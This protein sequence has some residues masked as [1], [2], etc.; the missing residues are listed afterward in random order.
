MTQAT[1]AAAPPEHLLMQMVTGKWVS[2]A[3][4]VVADLG[5]PDLLRDGARP[6]GELAQ[7]A[8]VAE[9]PLYRLLRAAAACGV[10]KELP[11]RRFENNALSNLMRTDVPG[12]LRAMVRWICEDCAWQAWGG[13]GYSVKSDRPAFDQVLGA[14]LFEYFKQHP[15]A[16]QVFN[17]AMINFTSIT[18][19]AVAKA[20]DFSAFDTIVDVGG[21]HGALL[22]TIAA[23][24]PR[25]RGIVFD[26]PEVVAGAETYLASCGIA[27]RI[28]TR[29]GDFLENVPP[30]AD[31]YIMKHIIHDW[32]DA[33]STRILSHCRNA[34]KAGGRPGKVLIVDQV[35][36][37]RPEGIFSKLAD[38]EMLVM[39]PGGRER[40]DAEFAELLRS[41][42]LTM[43]RIVPTESIVSIVEAVSQ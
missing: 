41:A 34:L 7:R 24:H 38:L 13:L 19:P 40:T 37:D 42:G 17:E 6:V 25:V 23:V 11:D 10:L 30:G 12:S 36:T 29:A 32:D 31:A 35:V 15:G 4:A 18:G 43:T 2:K 1:P 5:I 16:A 20:Y 9:D 21:G 22:A 3:L 28:D 27:D 26:R 8:G 39:T 33:R 14:D